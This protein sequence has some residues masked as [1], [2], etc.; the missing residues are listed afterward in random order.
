MACIT[1]HVPSLLLSEEKETKETKTHR[2]FCVLDLGPY[3]IFYFL[4]FLNLTSKKE[5]KFNSIF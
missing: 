5:N 3:H 2:F 4:K 1:G